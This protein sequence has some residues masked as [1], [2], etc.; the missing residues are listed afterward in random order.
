MFLGILMHKAE[1]AG[2]ELIPVNPASTSRTCPAPECGHISGENRTTQAD[3]VYVRCG[4]T[5]NADEVGATN[6]KRAGL[7]LRKAALAA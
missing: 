6:V 3:F 1:S 7:V 2:R 4:Y 5:A